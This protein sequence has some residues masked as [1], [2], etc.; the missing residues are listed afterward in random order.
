MTC[1]TCGA[2][3]FHSTTTDVTDLQSCL[4]I[5]RNV[6]CYKCSECDEELYTGDV[7][8]ELEKIT[9]AAKLAVNQ[10]ANTKVA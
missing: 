2:K 5:V 10:I 1:I 3:A 9:A 6:P 8:K 7:A 4:V